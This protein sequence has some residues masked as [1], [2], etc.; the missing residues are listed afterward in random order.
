MS[1]S[2]LGEPQFAEGDCECDLDRDWLYGHQMVHRWTTN[3]ENQ[4]LSTLNFD[5]FAAYV[6]SEVAAI[7]RKAGRE[8]SP[9]DAIDLGPG[10][11]IHDLDAIESKQPT[12][13]KASQT[14][15]DKAMDAKVQETTAVPSAENEHAEADPQQQADPLK[16]VDFDDSKRAELPRGVG[17]PFSLIAILL[18]AVALTVVWA[19]FSGR[20]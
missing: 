1:V 20:S 16:E 17:L 11:I 15:S 4:A 12:N 14:T 2:W 8:S 13:S 18:V 3:L 5:P 7:V 10:L 9:G 19:V 6:K